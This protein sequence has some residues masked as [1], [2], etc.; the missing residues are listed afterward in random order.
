MSVMMY[1]SYIV[2]IIDNLH[3]DKGDWVQPMVA[4]INCIVWTIYGF[5]CKPK[6]I[7]VIIANIP[8]IILGATAALTSLF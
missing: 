8:G 5:G 2:Q 3:G 4:C 6:Q 7:P 1:V